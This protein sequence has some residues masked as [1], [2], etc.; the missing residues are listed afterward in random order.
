[1]QKMKPSDPIRLVSVLSTTGP[2]HR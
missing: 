2:N 1:M